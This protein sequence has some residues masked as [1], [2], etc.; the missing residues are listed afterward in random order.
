MTRR[1]KAALGSLAFLVLAPG[2]VA[3]LVPWLITHWGPL[4]PA[5]G[6][7]SLRWSGLILIVAGVV[8]VLEAFARFAWDGLGTPAPIAP[9]T[10]LV[11]TGFF[12]RVRNPIYVALLIILLGEALLFGDERVAEWGVVFWLFTFAWVVIVEEPGLRQQFGEEY[13]T[14]CK[15]VPRWV[16]RI[17]PY[18]SSH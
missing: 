5:D 16:P 9:P 12:R 3:G 18:K 7:D 10:K 2:I 6:P 13:R 11:V 1:V 4:P 15:N 8:V 17:M 14:Y